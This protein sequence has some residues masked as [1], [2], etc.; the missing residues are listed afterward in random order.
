MPAASG[1]QIAGQALGTAAPGQHG[2]RGVKTGWVRFGHARHGERDRGR[3][4][5][6]GVPGWLA[7]RGWT[8][9]GGEMHET[10]DRLNARAAPVRSHR[11]C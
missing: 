7:D 1:Q 2:H 4:R 8:A 10:L 11:P 9:E 3:P 5:T 6:Y